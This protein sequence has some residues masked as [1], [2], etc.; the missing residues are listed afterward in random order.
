MPLEE[1]IFLAVIRIMRPKIDYVHVR[2]SRAVVQ[3]HELSEPVDFCS[4]M[5]S[6]GFLRSRCMFL[7]YLESYA[8]IP[9]ATGF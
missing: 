5:V 1:I 7:T 9:P 4:N 6:R 2:W 3:F 8:V